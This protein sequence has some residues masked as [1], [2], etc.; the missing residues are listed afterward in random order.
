MQNDQALAHDSEAGAGSLGRL[1]RG[2]KTAE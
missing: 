2:G 1:Q